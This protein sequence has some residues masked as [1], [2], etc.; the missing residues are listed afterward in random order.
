MHVVDLSLE[1]DRLHIGSIFIALGTILLCIG[2]DEALGIANNFTFFAVA[3]LCNVIEFLTRE[4][5]KISISPLFV[6]SIILIIVLDVI[7]MAF[8][9]FSR[10]AVMSIIFYLV[11]I[12]SV[13]L[14]SYS[15]RDARVISDGVIISSIVF[16]FLTMFLGRELYPGAGKYVYV[17]PFGEHVIIEPNYLGALMTL[18]FCLSVYHL[19]GP[20]RITHRIPV[21]F[22]YIISACIILLG[23]MLTGSRSALVSILLFAAAGILF[24]ENSP[25]KRRL[26]I[27]AAAGVTALLA[28]LFLGIIPDTVVSRMFN[29]SSYVDASNMKRIRDWL[30]GLKMMMREPLIGSGPELTQE[31]LMDFYGFSGD[32]HNT[33]ITAGIM[34]GLPVL[35]LFIYFIANLTMRAY[36]KRDTVMAAIMI[37][38]I[39]EW[40]IIACQFTVSTWLTF[41]ICMIMVN[42]SETEKESFRTD[43][44]NNGKSV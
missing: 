39:F 13:I 1:N 42:T 31:L 8:S 7:H 12:L 5:K 11:L 22:F 20:L 43:L 32:A 21:K 10:A 25:I 16:T 28:M 17:Q 33:F 37:A 9:S 30:Y 34:Y 35:A 19:M 27:L 24:M 23:I 40:N 26:F 3:I 18:G 4:S 6:F 38:M 41:I 36:K 44:D 15:F 29:L 2:Y 14:D